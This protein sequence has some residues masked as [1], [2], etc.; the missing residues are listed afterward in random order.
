MTGLYSDI[1]A[2]CCLLSSLLL[3]LPLSRRLWLIKN[4][5]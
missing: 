5:G 1:T 3:L 2:V 4:T